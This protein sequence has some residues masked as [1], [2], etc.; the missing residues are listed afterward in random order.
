MAALKQRGFKV[1][2]GAT[3]EEI[4]Q[5]RAAMQTP[6]FKALTDEAEEKMR[7]TFTPAIFEITNLTNLP[8]PF[9]SLLSVRPGEAPLHALT[10]PDHDD[11][12]P[13]STSPLHY[14]PFLEVDGKYYTFY[15]SGF[16]DRIA[17]I[18]EADLFAKRP[19]PEQISEM[20]ARRSVQIESES[21]KLLCSIIKPDFVD[22]NVY[23]PNPEKPGDLTE[24]DT[25]IGIDDILFLL[26]VKA[27]KLSDP[28]NRGAPESL[29]QEL[30]DLIAE[31]QRQA[32]RAEKYIQSSDEAVFYDNT[33]KNAVRKIKRS[34][35]RK[36]FRIVVT[37]EELGWVGANIAILS[38][39]E[40]SLS[41]SSPWH[42]SIDDLRIVAELF[43]D[44]EIR[45]VH[46]LEQRL[47]ASAQSKLKQ[48]DEIEHVGLYNK[49][50]Y[51]HE[52]PIREDGIDRMTFDPSYMRD[53]D[54]YFHD[55]AAG[56][57]PS[58]PTQTLPQKIKDL[59][60]ALQ[61]SEQPGRFEV[62]SII[63]SMDSGG[64][65]EF[66]QSLDHLDAG[67]TLG[68][69]RTIRAPFTSLSFGLTV[70]YADDSHWEE[71]LKRS[72]VQ[73]AQGKCG[74]WLVVQLANEA[75]YRVTKIDTLLPGRF[76][77]D[78][79]AE[80]EEHLEIKVR[81][82]IAT[83]KPGRNDKCPCGSGKKYK[84]CHGLH[85]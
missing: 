18:I 68:K 48:A 15:H 2:P 85:T 75:P 5:T 54:Y 74:R 47:R 28:A 17:E 11:L 45:F 7:L 26:E 30:S 80:S 61:S 29:A 13:L 82:A 37:R 77:D 79:L 65:D 58:V 34:S 38:V 10:G 44:S 27:G 16:E 84:R 3:Q 53:I 8:K 66:E 24:L 12:S 56:G 36:I 51:Y 33:G 64:R 83:T 76:T 57:N 63:L 60:A 49:M 46:F 32:E 6:E 55:K 78:D 40:P 23:Y 42:V 81:Q 62:G 35:V 1:E 71:E 59:I 25:L 69:Q 52:L 4:E 43:R 73:M 39:I 14:K 72:A 9:L 19:N 70:T 41:S 20:T 21:V 31:G 22:K 67:R 50:N